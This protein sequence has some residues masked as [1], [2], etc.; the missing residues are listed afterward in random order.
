MLYLD[1]QKGK[2]A[3]KTPKFKQHI[4]GTAV[5]TKILIVD[6]KGCGKMK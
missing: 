2:E 5:C 4:G 3:M 1:I 6:R